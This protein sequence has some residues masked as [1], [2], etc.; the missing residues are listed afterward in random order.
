MKIEKSVPKANI[1][2]CFKLGQEIAELRSSL[3]EAVHEL[4]EGDISWAK[5]YLYD[6]AAHAKELTLLYPG[7]ATSGIARGI[8]KVTIEIDKGGVSKIGVLGAVKLQ[9]KVATLREESQNLRASAKVHCN[10][11]L[12][13]QE[14]RKA[15]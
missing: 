2:N 3:N 6:A 8:R 13:F 10:V 1:Q 12:P 5:T 14:K 7:Q 4:S 15:R 11:P 9:K